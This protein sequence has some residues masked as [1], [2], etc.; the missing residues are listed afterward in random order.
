M[1]YLHLEKQPPILVATL[2][3]FAVAAHPCSGQLTIV[4]GVAH[5]QDLEGQ[6]GADVRFGIDP[7]GLPIGGFVGADYFLTNC[8]VNCGLRGHRV[9]VIFRTSAPVIQPYLTGAYVV[10]DREYEDVSERRAGPA[11]GAGLRV[12]TVIKIRAEATWEF[13]GGKLNHWVFRIG[14]GL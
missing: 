1:G 13:L 5:T 4:G 8:P 6:W 10:R 12:A 3:L 7:P 14:L 11:L 9:G 2:I